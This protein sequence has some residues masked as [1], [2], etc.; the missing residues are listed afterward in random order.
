MSCDR[1]EDVGAL[2]LGGLDHE[3]AI[4]VEAHVLGCPECAAERR[5]LS[6]V[7]TLLDSFDPSSDP[8]ATADLPPA[9]GE[10]VVARLV[11]TPRRNRGRDV[12]MVLLG[13]AAAVVLVVGGL[14]IRNAVHTDSQE[15]ALELV[16]PAAAPE[17]WGLVT[18]HPRVDGTIVDIEAGDL[19]TDEGT[20]NVTVRGDDSVIASQD[21]EVDTDGWAQVLL[22]TSRPMEQ[23]DVIEITR[24]DD[25]SPATLLR[26]SCT[27]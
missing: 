3:E 12:S 8:S 19:P 27:P 16:S 1:R 5:E 24:T 9:L 18:L 10:Q 22:A 11:A 14:T 26:C 23:G 15:Q 2:L 6:I 4:E 17:A 25:A 13:A 20:F 7:R 21:F